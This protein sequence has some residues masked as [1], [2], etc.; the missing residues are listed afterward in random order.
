M[1]KLRSWLSSLLVLAI[2]AAPVMAGN[3]DARPENNSAASPE[4]S[5][6]AS[7]DPNPSPSP[8]LNLSSAT[9]DSNV[10]ALLGVLVM[11]GVLAPNEANSIRNAAPSAQFQALVE[12]LSQK[13]VVNAQDLSAISAAGPETALV[14]QATNAPGPSPEKPAST[15]TVVAAITPVRVLPIDA[16][17]KDGLI[18]ALKLGAVRMTPYGFIKATLAHDSSDPRGDDFIVPGFLNADTG[19]NTNPSFHVKAR[20]T[21]FGANFEWPDISKRLTLT[22]KVEGDFEGNFGR[23]DNRNISSVRSNMPQLRLAFARLDYAASDQTDIFF[24]GGQDWTLFGSSAQAN[25][26]ETTFANAYWGDVYERSPQMRIGLIQKFGG[27]RNVKFSPEFAV[28]MPSEGNLPA[29]ATISSCSIPATFTPGTTTTI[30]CS[31]TVVNGLGNQLGYGERQGADS[32]RPEL[33][34]RAVLQWQLDKAPAVAPAQFIVSGFDARRTAQVLHSAIAAPAGSSATTVANYAFIST[35]PQFLHG[36]TN[37]STGYGVQVAAQL[38]TRWAT[39]VASAYK[40]ADLRFFF[41]GQLLSNYNDEAGLTN[42]VTAPSVDRSSTVVFGMNAAGQAALAPQRSIR[43]YGGFAQL[44]L[45]LSRLFNADPK[46]RNAGWTLYFQG[47]LDAVDHHDFVRA[48]GTAA[49]S[50]PYRSVYEGVSLFHKLNNWVTFGYELSL[51][52]SYALP[53]AAGAF[54]SATSVAGVPSRTWRDLREEFGP[55]FTF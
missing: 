54:T 5:A 43:G 27:S 40:G 33:E 46:G 55:I 16:P 14:N 30:A 35:S 11:K 26:L 2:M 31:S 24:E 10:T 17:V 1:L 6:A 37:S 50:G 19:P 3:N 32:G 22:G 53:N 25:L 23:S 48:K 45:P 38:P 29:D 12:A 28:M 44:G 41:G 4:A 49:S 51:Y 18:P 47:G 42:A 36:A 34:G 7:P 21:R 20:A 39:L 9:S 8:S 52:S 15:P 13:G